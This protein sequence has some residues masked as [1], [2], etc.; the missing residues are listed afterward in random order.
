MSMLN[1]AVKVLRDK[2]D[3]LFK[4]ECPSF[5]KQLNVWLFY[6][7]LNLNLEQGNLA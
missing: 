6:K 3:N 4:R 7:K 5:P 2:L 1:S